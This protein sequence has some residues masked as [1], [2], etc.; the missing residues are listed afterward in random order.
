MREA[1]CRQHRRV[2]KQ[3]GA[4]RQV[5]TRNG[6]DGEGGRVQQSGVLGHQHKW[7]LPQH[8]PS[9]GKKALSA[10]SV[11]TRHHIGTIVACSLE[12]SERLQDDRLGSPGLVSVAGGNGAIGVS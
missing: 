10:G 4:E 9:C 7:Q 2:R 3:S 12:L 6:M 5:I 1:L 8:S 11:A